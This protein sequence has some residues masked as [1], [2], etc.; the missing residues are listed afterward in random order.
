MSRPDALLEIAEPAEQRG[1][2]RGQELALRG[3]RALAVFPEIPADRAVLLQI[4]PVGI[5]AHAPCRI[6]VDHIEQVVPAGLWRTVPPGFRPGRD[7]PGPVVQ[8]SADVP[9]D[10]LAS[11]PGDAVVRPRRDMPG[12]EQHGD[13]VLAVVADRAGAAPFDR[14]QRPVAPE[15]VFDRD[16][17]GFGPAARNLAVDPAGRAELDRTHH[18]AHEI[19]QTSQVRDFPDRA[20]DVVCSEGFQG[21][22]SI[23]HATD[24]LPETC[25]FPHGRG[26]QRHCGARYARRRFARLP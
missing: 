14:K 10:A 11:C 26:I 15:F 8:P 4:G 20:L 13:R 24:P 7:R 5:D 9:G 19:V 17:I 6:A 3:R 12:G 21:G 1:V 2:F 16:G 22:L 23:P 18:A 25:S